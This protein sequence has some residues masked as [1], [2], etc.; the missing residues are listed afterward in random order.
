MLLQLNLNSSIHGPCPN[1]FVTNINFLPLD[2]F[3]PPPHC[4][5]AANA[6]ASPSGAP[7]PNPVVAHAMNNLGM[8]YMLVGK[9]DEAL[10]YF[11]KVWVRLRQEGTQLGLGA[12][13]PNVGLGKDPTFP[14]KQWHGLGD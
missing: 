11:Q 4:V 14:T 8:I 6:V 12:D 1:N 7:T 2:F 3:S 9:D 10:H 13:L 5:L